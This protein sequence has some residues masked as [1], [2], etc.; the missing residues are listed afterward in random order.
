MGDILVIVMLIV[1]VLLGIKRRVIRLLMSSVIVAFGF[2]ATAGLYDKPGFFFN[3]FKVLGYSA[4]Y[5]LGFVFTAILVVFI[6]EIL[7]RWA[8]KDTALPRLRIVDNIL[9]A[10]AG[11]LWGLLLAGLFMAPFKSLHNSGPLS[12]VVQ[13]LVR[14]IAAGVL[15]FFPGDPII[16]SLAG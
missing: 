7:F 14:P 9:G 6:F 10:F 3:S 13:V 5:S 15:F 16:R 12:S 8:F 1:G 2:F 4:S 11:I